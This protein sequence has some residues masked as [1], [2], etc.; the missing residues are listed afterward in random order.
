MAPA[1]SA[2]AVDAKKNKTAQ[3]P[4]LG[5][6]LEDILMQ[7]STKK[8]TKE[9]WDS[10]NVRFVGA[11]RV[12]TTRLGTLRGEWELLRM[13]SDESLDAFAGK[14]GGMAARL[15]GSERRWRTQLW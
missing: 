14:I 10:I 13:A 11:D 2:A 12:R 6:L 1:D 8:T 3:A 4:Q 15:Q 5:A 7:V 9:I